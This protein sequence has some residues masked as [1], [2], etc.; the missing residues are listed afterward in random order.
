MLKVFRQAGARRFRHSFNRGL[1]SHVGEGPS[2]PTLYG[3]QLDYDVCIIGGGHAGCEAA[4][5][6]ARSGAR[7]LLIT[8]KLDTIGEMSCNPSF[9]GVGKGTLVREIDALDGVCAKVAGES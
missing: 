4:A 3:K 8:Q 7:T 5:G 1:A 6:A 9:G 2:K